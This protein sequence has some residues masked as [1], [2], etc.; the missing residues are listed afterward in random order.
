M[1]KEQNSSNVPLVTIVVPSFNQGQ[2]LEAAL[3]SIFA[4]ELPLE[5]FVNDGGS[6]DNSVEIIRKY[7]SQ[8]TGWRSLKDAGQSAAINEG[9]AQGT[10][11]YVCWL[12]SDDFFHA[13]ALQYLIKVLSDNPES[14][15]VYGACSVSNSNGD[16]INR[17]LSLPPKRYFLANYCFI[18]QPGTLI[19]RRCWE[20]LKG[21][22]N[23]YHMAMDY[24]L[25]WRLWNKFGQPVYANDQLVS[26][27]R[28]HSDTK[29][30]V[31]IKGH[32]RESINVVKEH[33]GRVPLKWY[34]VYPIM[35]IVRLIEKLRY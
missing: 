4:Q 3:Q 30:A 21:L 26:S 17:Y 14:P 25:W 16:I 12:N 5:V 6:T 32:Y 2:Y 10:A 22:N 20:S 11:P 24:D 19:K 27:T 15:F 35:K 13:G 1:S 29:T 7:E 28:A 34:F 33:Y 9:V 31:N 8:L 18:C 23:N